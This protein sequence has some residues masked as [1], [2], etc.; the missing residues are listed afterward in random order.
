MTEDLAEYETLDRDD[1]DPGYFSLPGI[2]ISL[3]NPRPEDIRAAIRYMELM[4]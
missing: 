3:D 4:T 1:Y 2:E